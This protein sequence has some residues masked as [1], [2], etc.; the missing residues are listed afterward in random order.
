MTLV[1]EVEEHMSRSGLAVL[2]FELT[3][4]D[5]VDDQEGGTA[6][7]FQTTGIG[8]IGKPG[9][10]VGDQVDAADVADAMLSPTG[11]H[12]DGLHDMTLARAGLSSH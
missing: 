1:D 2:A 7:A 5:V 10:Q 12:G 4:S 6:P 11:T 3:E 8:V 9:V